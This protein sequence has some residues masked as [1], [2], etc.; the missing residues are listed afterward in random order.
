MYH[1]DSITPSDIEEITKFRDKADFICN[2][3]DELYSFLIKDYPNPYNRK[4]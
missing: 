1:S 2:K 3:F 4:R